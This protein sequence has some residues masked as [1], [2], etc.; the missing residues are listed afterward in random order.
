MTY[1]YIVKL[2]L[3]KNSVTLFLTLA[4]HHHPLIPPSRIVSQLHTL[5]TFYIRLYL[6]YLILTYVYKN[7][8]LKSNLPDNQF[9]PFSETSTTKN[10]KTTLVLLRFFSGSILEQFCIYFVTGYLNVSNCR[11]TDETVLDRNQLGEAC[12]VDYFDV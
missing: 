11:A 2:D 9:N 10:A 4:D 7:K 6:L 8:Y 3:S 1:W 5:S 12:F